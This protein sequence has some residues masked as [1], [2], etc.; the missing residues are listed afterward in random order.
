MSDYYQDLPLTNFP[1]A[2]DQRI[3]ML[4]PSMPEDITLIK[5]F[6]AAM[7]SKNILLATQILRDNPRLEK[8]IFNAAKFNH[9]E[10]AV[11]AIQRMW[12][13][14]ISEY[15]RVAI[16]TV[17]AGVTMN[18]VYGLVDALAGKSA[19]NH[20]HT[21]EEIGIHS[22]TGEL[23]PDDSWVG[24]ESPYTQEVDVAGVTATNNVD[25]AIGQNAS[26]AQLEAWG[27]SKIMAVA[28]SPGKLTFRA[29]GSKPSVTLPF[30]VK[31]Y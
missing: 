12:N 9:L 7:D 13:S 6:Q 22:T 25:A 2:V 16:E 17:G 4:D 3:V 8:M 11:I 5:S 26:E 24:D 21:S 1:D 19:I 30:I 31:L 29:F 28:Q 14:D 18:Q 23:L 15:L 10:D 20:T 27:E